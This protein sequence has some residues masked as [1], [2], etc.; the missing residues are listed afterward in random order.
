MSRASIF[1]AKALQRRAQRTE[2][3]LPPPPVPS[4]RAVGL[5]WALLV[6]ALAG[7]AAI[8]STLT[9]TLDAPLRG[10]EHAAPLEGR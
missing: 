1:R 9:S 8:G 3:P 7:L 5:L 6:L 10:T 4:N 2:R